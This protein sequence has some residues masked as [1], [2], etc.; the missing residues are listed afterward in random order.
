MKRRRLAFL[1]VA[2][3]FDAS[4]VREHTARVCGIVGQIDSLD[5]SAI[6]RHGQCRPPGTNHVGLGIILPVGALRP[7]DALSLC[8]GARLEQIID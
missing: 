1:A 7:V 8:L 4:E 2:A 6:E 3:V 5:E